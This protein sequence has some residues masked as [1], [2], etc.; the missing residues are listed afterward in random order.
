ME[1]IYFPFLLKLAEHGA[2]VLQKFN[3]W[4]FNG[5]FAHRSNS[6]YKNMTIGLC[7]IKQSAENQAGQGKK[8][9]FNV[10]ILWGYILIFAAG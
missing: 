8:F 10:D 3:K 7:N 1:A 2:N 9:F 4:A 6:V 5:P